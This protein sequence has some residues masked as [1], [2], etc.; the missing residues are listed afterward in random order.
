MVV[1]G[2]FIIEASSKDVFK[3]RFRRVEELTG[4]STGGFDS[5]E[6]CDGGGAWRIITTA[7]FENLEAVKAAFQKVIKF[8]WFFDLDSSLLI[9]GKEIYCDGRWHI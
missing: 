8:K 9:N 7:E 2:V 1:E 4:F 3:N 6:K 5:Y